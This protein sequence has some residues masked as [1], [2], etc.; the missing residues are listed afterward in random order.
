MGSEKSLGSGD[1]KAAR[2]LAMAKKKEE[3]KQGLLVHIDG[4]SELVT[5]QSREDIDKILGNRS[6]MVW[7]ERFW[8]LTQGYD[9][10]PSYNER[11]ERYKALVGF[12][13]PVLFTGGTETNPQTVLQEDLEEYYS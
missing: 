12:R 7:R 10:M 4:T 1:Q 2:E 13:G 11:G 3:L 5:F 9:H 6:C 8:F